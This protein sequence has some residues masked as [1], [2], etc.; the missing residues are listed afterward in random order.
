[1]GAEDIKASSLTSSVGLLQSFQSD[2]L[3]ISISERPLVQVKGMGETKGK[4]KKTRQPFHPT[5][6]T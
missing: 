2:T 1:M 3:R 6:R 4:K 5:E